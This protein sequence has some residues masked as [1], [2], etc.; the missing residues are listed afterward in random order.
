MIFLIFIIVLIATADES[1]SDTWSAI[2]GLTMLGC[3]AI[4]I[5]IGIGRLL[6]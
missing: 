2:L 6:F 1:C 5:L 3:I 4:L